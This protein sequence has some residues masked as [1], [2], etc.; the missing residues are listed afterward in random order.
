MTA[1]QRFASDRS[2]LQHACPLRLGAPL[3]HGA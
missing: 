1:M 3:P 2:L